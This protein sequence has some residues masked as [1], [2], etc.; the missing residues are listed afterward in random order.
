MNE[1]TFRVLEYDKVKNI[2]SGYSASEAGRLSVLMSIPGSNPEE[3]ERLLGETKELFSLLQGGEHPPLDNIRNIG[4]TVEK[5]RATGAMLAP[6]ELL[7]VAVTLGVGRRV[8][9]FFQKFVGK[10]SEGRPVT[11]LLWRSA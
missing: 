8:R 5:V 6:A 9:S 10:P 2:V 3:V 1:H 4:Y 7:D 11:P